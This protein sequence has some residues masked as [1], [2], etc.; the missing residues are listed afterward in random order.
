MIEL[1]EVADERDVLLAARLD[2]RRYYRQFSDRQIIT[3]SSEPRLLGRSV[4]FAYCTPLL[5]QSRDSWKLLDTVRH[6]M[7]RLTHELPPEARIKPVADWEQDSWSDYVA[8]KRAEMSLIER[9]YARRF[10][11]GV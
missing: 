8:M 7:L 9:E 11:G 1:P 4:R 5:N 10:G 2:E 3:P 6:S